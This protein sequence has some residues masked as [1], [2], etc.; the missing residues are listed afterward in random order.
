MRIRHLVMT[1]LVLAPLAAGCGGGKTPPSATAPAPPPAVLAPK[2]VVGNAEVSLGDVD[3]GT[4]HDVPF[5]V[6]NQGTAP[7]KLTLTQK[8][9]YCAEVDVPPEI[10]P[11]QEGKITVRWKPI[12]GSPTNYVMQADVATNDPE[13][14]VLSFRVRATIKALVQTYVPDPD[15]EARKQYYI[16]FGD[17]PIEPGEGR[18]REV[19]VYSSELSGFDLEARCTHP[20]LEVLPLTP[21]PP[22]TLPDGRE[23]RSGYN[24]VLQATD[25]LPRGYVQENL[26]LTVKI[27]DKPPRTLTMPVYANVWNGAFSVTP[28]QFVFTKPRITEADSFKVNV[29]F[30]GVPKEDRIEVVR[31]EPSFLKAEARRVAPGRWQVTANLPADNAE[32]ARYQADLF[33]EGKIVLKG[34][35]PAGDVEMPVRVKW[36]PR[37]N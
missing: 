6:A 19:K 11:G 34:A 17:R 1:V 21:L 37:A 31:V 32:A 12:P 18:Q 25:K 29:T 13:N 26:E 35:G 7:L 22:G 4:Q 30:N 28:S 10:A 36:D 9:C 20:G 24:V 15:R 33:M 23:V 27:K 8:S 14:A 3:Y 2:A 5:T 16:D